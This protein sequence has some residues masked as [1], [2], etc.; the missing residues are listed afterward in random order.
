M[1]SRLKKGRDRCLCGNIVR[2]T[3]WP[4]DLRGEETHRSVGVVKAVKKT[5]AI[6][7]CARQPGGGRFE[8]EVSA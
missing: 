7:G 8:D 1:V 4:V 5:G 2:R 6:H 3:F